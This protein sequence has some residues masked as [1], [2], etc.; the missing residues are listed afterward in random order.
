MAPM[1]NRPDSPF[2]R[3]RDAPNRNDSKTINMA[4]VGSLVSREF[5]PVELD[6]RLFYVFDMG[7]ERDKRQAIILHSRSYL[8][9]PDFAR[10]YKK[11]LDAL[12][13]EDGEYSVH[14][15]PQAT[16]DYILKQRKGETPNQ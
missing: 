2:R 6:G 11:T 3:G 8:E 4:L 13:P 1:H 16:I 7:I 10:N 9:D 14:M 15:E 5:T 12:K